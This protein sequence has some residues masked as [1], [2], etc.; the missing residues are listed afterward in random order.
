MRILASA[1]LL[2]SVLLLAGCAA[3]PA[4]PG[5]STSMSGSMTGSSM[6]TPQ[7]VEVTMQNTAF[8]P[9]AITIHVGDTVHWTDKD[10]AKPHNVVSKSK[11]NEFTSPDMDAALPTYQ[12]EYSHTFTA[13]GTVDYVCTYHGSMVATITVEA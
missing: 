5:A 11:G 12:K 2:L 8:S 6:H 7:T 1:L 4:A 9:K 13:A 3:K 10:A